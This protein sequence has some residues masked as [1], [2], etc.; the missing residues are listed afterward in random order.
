[1]SKEHA[2]ERSKQISLAS[3]RHAAELLKPLPHQLYRFNDLKERER[4]GFP[5]GFILSPQCRAWRAEDIERWLASRSTEQIPARG[6]AKELVE[7]AA[8]P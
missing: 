5:P 8:R 4:D 3:S 2:P 6:R 1:M 7:K